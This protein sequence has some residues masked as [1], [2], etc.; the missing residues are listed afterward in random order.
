MDDRLDQRISHRQTLWRQWLSTNTRGGIIENKHY[1]FCSKAKDYILEV[2]YISTFHFLPVTLRQSLYA[3][4]TLICMRD[5]FGGQIHMVT[6]DLFLNPF[7]RPEVFDSLDAKFGGCVFIR[8][9]QS[10]RVQL[11]GR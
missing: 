9:N 4:N 1:G 6:L 3:P 11:Q 5:P 8:N 2:T 7:D 10:M